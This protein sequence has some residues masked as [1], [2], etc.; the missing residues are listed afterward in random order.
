MS[1]NFWM[2]LLHF[3]STNVPVDQ[4]PSSLPWISLPASQVIS[5][6]PVFILIFFS[7][8]FSSWRKMW[9]HHSLFK[10]SYCFL[11]ISVKKQTKSNQ[12]SLRGQQDC[13]W[14]VDLSSI[15]FLFPYKKFPMT[16]I[17]QQLSPNSLP[18]PSQC[19]TFPLPRTHYNSVVLIGLGIWLFSSFSSLTRVIKI[20]TN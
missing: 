15:P 12:H 3:I 4:A 11:F 10:T 17:S 5:L 8:E 18:L 2:S 19:S 6:P 16:S 1:I 14:I 20:L 7:A 13:Y 9:S